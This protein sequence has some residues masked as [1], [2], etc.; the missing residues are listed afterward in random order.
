MYDDKGAELDDS[1]YYK[2][3]RI[4]PLKITNNKNIPIEVRKIYISAKEVK[5]VDS[6][7]FVLLNRKALEVIC[8][9]ENINNDK[10]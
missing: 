2:A 8:K 5:Y 7:A 6:D 3:T 4:Y 1:L 10:Y 9:L